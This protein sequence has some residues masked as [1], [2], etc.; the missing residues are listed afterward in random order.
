[1]PKRILIV[2][3]D[4]AS[5][6]A[7][8]ACMEPLGVDVDIVGNADEALFAIERI[9]PDLILIGAGVDGAFD[10]LG[11][12]RGMSASLPLVVV[13]PRAGRAE[14]LR[15]VEAGA[16]DCLVMPGDYAVLA[17]RARTLLA[18]KAV[19]DALRARND[20]LATLDNQR[21]EL[22]QFVVH[23]L[24]NPLSTL[25]ANVNWLM[26]VVTER[27]EIGEALCDTESAVRR[28][29]SMVDDLLTITRIED[30]ALPIHRADIDVRPIIDELVRD[31]GREARTAHLSIESSVPPHL[32]LDVDAMVFRRMLDN[33]VDNA[34]R[35]TPTGGR[36]L[37]QVRGENPAELCIANTGAPIPIEN[38]ELIFRKF[39]RGARTPTAVN[40]G[41][42]LY[43]CKLAAEAHGGS[44]DL[45]STTEWPVRFTVRIPTNRPSATG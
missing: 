42:G 18:Q 34:L 17:A 29:Q 5:A 3:D 39:E 45:D 4:R 35:Y 21:R 23:D 10:L 43:F 27:A 22:A 30:A 40:V 33:L 1:M 37:V 8:G 2:D 26:E 16:D 32:F 41:I 7:V 28:L 20:E 15:A 44:I 14:R 11:H 31:H 24:K 9:R 25:H 13:T 19:I 36:I 6:A 38:R 12:V